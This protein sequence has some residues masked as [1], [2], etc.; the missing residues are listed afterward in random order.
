HRQLVGAQVLAHLHEGREDGVDGE[1]A[2]HGQPGQQPGQAARPRGPGGAGAGT[3]GAHTGDSWGSERASLTRRQGWPGY[4]R[5]H[6]W[7]EK[8]A[9]PAAEG[10]TP[11]IA[12]ARYHPGNTTLERPAP[13]RRRRGTRS[14]TLRLQT[15]RQ[16]DRGAT[17]TAWSGRQR[18]RHLAGPPP[19]SPAGCLP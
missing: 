9:L 18:G 15:L 2:E 8:P 11:V 17:R 10:A 16:K 3:G 19:P 13:S 5:R 12:Q 4:N 14:S 7:W 1:R 6:P